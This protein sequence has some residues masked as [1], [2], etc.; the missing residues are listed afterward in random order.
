MY[1]KESTCE[2]SVSDIIHENGFVVCVT[3]GEIFRR[4]L[5]TS[6]VSFQQQH[7]R[8]QTLYSRRSRFEKKVLGSLRRFTNH[9]ISSDL[10]DFLL[11]HRP[12]TPQ[13]LLRNI[14]L[15]KTT[16]RRPYQHAMDYW[17]ALGNHQPVCTDADV[18]LLKVKFDDFFFAWERLQ[19]MRP[20]FPY[21]YLFN[22]IVI[23]SEK[24]SDGMKALVQFVRILRCRKRKKRYDILYEKC[25]NFNYQI[26]YLENV[27]N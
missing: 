5:E 25:V 26:L 13:E 19:L 7:Y 15:W 24:F 23:G 8:I 10:M 2:C 6:H 17:V 3:C 14:S 18:R 11:K 21:A 1:S 22:K 20:K 12:E 16:E 4:S 9:E 27:H